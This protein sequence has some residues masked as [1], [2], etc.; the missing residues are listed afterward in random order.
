[1]KKNPLFASLVLTL[2]LA[3]GCVT[4]TRSGRTVHTHAEAVQILG[5]QIPQDP[6]TAAAANFPADAQIESV[7]VSPA[8]LN[9]V[10]GFLHRLWGLGFAS[11][12]GTSR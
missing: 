12:G 11:I 1:M 9:T 2:L 5:L 4:T 10:L 7:I 6:Q 8:D 3:T